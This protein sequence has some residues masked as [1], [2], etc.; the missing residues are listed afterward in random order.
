MRSSR[1][2][3]S[4]GPHPKIR[5]CAQLLKT[6]TAVEGVQP[7]VRAACWQCDYCPEPRPHA[8]LPE[9]GHSAARGRARWA[10]AGMGEAGASWRGSVFHAVE[11]L[12]AG[13]AAH[14]GEALGGALQRAQ[15]GQYVHRAVRAVV[16][17]GRLAGAPA[18]AD[19][20]SQTHLQSLWIT[21][22]FRWTS[23]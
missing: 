16:Q 2:F 13:G 19:L 23:A 18:W 22:S 7:L 3:P 5:G 10:G 4:P 21:L 15:R 8:G 6:I 11:A 17:A 14:A 20:R 1:Y 9:Q 12:V